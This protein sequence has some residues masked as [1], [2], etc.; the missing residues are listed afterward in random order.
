M[1][2]H[3]CHLWTSIYSTY[4]HPFVSIYKCVDNFMKVESQTFLVSHLQTNNYIGY[5]RNTH[6]NHF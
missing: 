4:E 1:I 5:L 2:I 6:V 3:I